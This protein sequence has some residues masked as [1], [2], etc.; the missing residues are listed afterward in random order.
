MGD[1][2]GM[3]RCVLANVQ[4]RSGWG[5]QDPLCQAMIADRAWFA[6]ADYCEE[7]FLDLEEG[8]EYAAAMRE[9]AREG[10]I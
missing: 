2:E 1:M 10:A 7:T 3:R 6:L 4:P 5:D 8:R 9:L